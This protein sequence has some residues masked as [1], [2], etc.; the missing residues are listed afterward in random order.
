MRI[1]MADFHLVYDAQIAAA[2]RLLASHAHTLAEGGRRPRWPPL[3]GYGLISREK[4]DFFPTRVRLVA[5]IHHAL[6]I[7]DGDDSPSMYGTR[8]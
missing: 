7:T 2:Q 3:S 6:G 5:E 8:H 4:Y 1:R